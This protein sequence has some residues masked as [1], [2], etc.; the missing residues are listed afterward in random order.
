[1]NS[2]LKLTSL[3]SYEEID[4]SIILTLESHVSNTSV[5]TFFQKLFSKNHFITLDQNYNEAIF[6]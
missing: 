6:I 1:M 5:I 4:N 2:V 3:K